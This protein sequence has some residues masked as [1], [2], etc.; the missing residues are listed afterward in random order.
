MGLLDRTTGELGKAAMALHG[1]PDA[2]VNMTGGA[3]ALPVVSL[4][5]SGAG[6]ALHQHAQTWLSLMRGRKVWFVM[7]PDGLQGHNAYETVALRTPAEW[8]EH[9]LP[10]LLGDA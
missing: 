2:L 6:L 8:P 4:G 5:A 9:M 1:V 3:D 10:S 7:A